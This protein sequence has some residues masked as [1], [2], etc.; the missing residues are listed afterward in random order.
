MSRR[1]R[2]KR[3]P[4]DLERKQQKIIQQIT[5]RVA[6]GRLHLQAFDDTF[7]RLEAD[8]PEVAISASLHPEMDFSLAI[9]VGAA[10]DDTVDTQVPR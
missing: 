5:D 3:A 10:I 9:G 7:S 8:C 6:E 1:E 2:K 4:K